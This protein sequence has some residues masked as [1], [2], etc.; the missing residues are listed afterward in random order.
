M[1]PV[2][3]VPDD[4]TGR[5]SSLVAV[6]TKHSASQVLSGHSTCTLAFWEDSLLPG[7]TITPLFA[8]WTEPSLWKS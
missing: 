7:I 4:R 3:S 5:L 6:L 8:Q 1:E 2:P